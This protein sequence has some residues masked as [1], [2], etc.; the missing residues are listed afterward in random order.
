MRVCV[1]VCVRAPLGLRRNSDILYPDGPDVSMSGRPVPA[2]RASGRK[3][4]RV[5]SAVFLPVC[6]LVCV[7]Y[8]MPLFPLSF[9]VWFLFP[10]LLLFCRLLPFL[11]CLYS[12]FCVCVAVMLIFLL[13]FVSG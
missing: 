1:C 10:L 5:C 6:F 12:V 2:R 3:R 11:F 4:V 7:R 9:C 13:L 8:V